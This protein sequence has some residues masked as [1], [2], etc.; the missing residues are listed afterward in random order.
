MEVHNF[1][2][3][4]VKIITKESIKHGHRWIINHAHRRELFSNELGTEIER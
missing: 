3:I 4:H 2:D 1:S